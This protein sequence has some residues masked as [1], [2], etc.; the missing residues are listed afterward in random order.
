MSGPLIMLVGGGG[1]LGYLAY[2]WLQYRM[3][4]RI[5]RGTLDSGT[6]RWVSY[7]W[8]VYAIVVVTLVLTFLYARP[9]DRI[10]GEEIPGVEPTVEVAHSYL[11]AAF[12][13][14]IGLFWAYRQS[15]KEAVSRRALITFQ[16]GE[17]IHQFK[18][19]FRIRP[20]VFNA[21]EEAN[22]KI[23]P[24]V[25]QAIGH[26]VTTFYVTSLPQRAFTELKEKIQDP[27]MEQFVYI[28]QR[29][30]DA[31]HEDIMKALDGL[32]L[33][34]RRARE[35]RDQSEVNMTVITGQTRI[36]QMI[37]V[38]LV[39]V[40]G[41]VPLFR[42]AYET[43]PGQFLFMF[44]AGIGVGTSFYIDRKAQALREKVL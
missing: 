13:F 26:A 6:S 35:L 15:K 34:M 39:L 12:I 30:E 18:S 14:V 43:L 32:L 21:L 22:R 40:V 11:V 4:R 5:R 24:P 17:L 29:G 25:G 8:R 28:L 41:L 16:V 37:A 10:V 31:K 7:D 23:E 20:T 33:R 1:L 19:V 36:I 44:I 9:I 3:R 38:T 2:D 42:V 27:Y